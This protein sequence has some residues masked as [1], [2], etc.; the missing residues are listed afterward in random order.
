MKLG[1]PSGASVASW[2]AAI[3]VCVALFG[4]LLGMA[5]SSPK[6]TSFSTMLHEARPESGQRNAPPQEAAA[7]SAPVT[8]TSI[9]RTTVPQPQR[10]QHAPAGSHLV[11]HDD[12][13]GAKLDPAKWIGCF[14]WAPTGCNNPPNNSMEWFTPSQATVSD[15]ML[16]ITAAKDP[17]LG[18]APDGSPQMYPY[19][20]ANVTTAG[21]FDFTYGY[22]Q[23]RANFPIGRGLWPA[24]WMLSSDHKFPPEIDIMEIQNMIPGKV[25][26]VFHGVATQL[27]QDV[28]G[29][30]G[31][32]TYGLL[33]EPGS[34][35]WYIDG[36]PKLNVTAEVP[37]EP[38][39]LLVTMAVG[40]DWPGPPTADTPFPSTLDVSDIQVWQ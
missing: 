7:P 5:R 38:M 40:G 36:V 6:P 29:V 30:F 18:Q 15:G 35:T 28:Y 27:G 8:A 37:S 17:I 25:A 14:P 21:K 13:P 12:F 32:H 33:W 4:G 10:P 23:F 24:I 11:F 19:R 34:L 16:H 1:R 31:W 3:V 22:V 9:N 39:Y 26:E 2:G 20:S